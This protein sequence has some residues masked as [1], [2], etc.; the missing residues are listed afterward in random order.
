L[1]GGRDAFICRGI[2]A[3]MM[4]VDPFLRAATLLLLLLLLLLLMM[5]MMM[6]HD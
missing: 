2:T 5:M 1:K 6:M 4:T 3:I